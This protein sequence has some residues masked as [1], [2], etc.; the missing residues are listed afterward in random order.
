[1]TLRD[2]IYLYDIPNIADGTYLISKSQSQFDDFYNTIDKLERMTTYSFIE[3]A[4]SIISNY[5]EYES[6]LGYDW[7]DKTYN[8]KTNK[9]IF[10]SNDLLHNIQDVL[11][12]FCAAD[13]I[14]TT[15]RILSRAGLL[16]KWLDIRYDHD[17]TTEQFV[18]LIVALA[19]NNPRYFA[20]NQ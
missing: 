2:K 3:L 15:T 14:A 19:L 20:Y 6:L 1:M 18:I 16:N 4:L 12:M 7:N 5:P 13:T 9:T 8:Y 17:K 10:S 11:D